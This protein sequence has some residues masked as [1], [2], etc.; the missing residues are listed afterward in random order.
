LL[1]E[2]IAITDQA[3]A[4]PC[5]LR[6]DEIIALSENSVRLRDILVLPCGDLEH[7]EG[8]EN[9]VIATL[10][11]DSRTLSLTRV[12][13]ADLLARRIPALAGLTE[14]GNDQ[15]ITF[16][17]SAASEVRPETDTQCYV[18][19]RNI[20]PGELVTGED[21]S[22][23]EC[24]A[25]RAASRIAYDRREGVP[26]TSE[27]IHQGDYLGRLM[28][29]PRSNWDVGQQ[30]TMS[31]RVGPVAVERQVWAMEPAAGNASVFLKDEYGAVFS[32]PVS[33]LAKK[34]EAPE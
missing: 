26:R 20:A 10:P 31:I 34:A 2:L 7:F 5:E 21:V 25:D 18:A 15:R 28:P 14:S 32:A 23:S 24:L 27:V 29:L 8:A 30:L 12:G 4:P 33:M 13:V 19:T 22:Q 1:V 6:Q 16:T 11:R 17:N 9:L 3:G